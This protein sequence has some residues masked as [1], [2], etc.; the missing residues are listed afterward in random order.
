MPQASGEGA[1]LDIYADSPRHDVGSLPGHDLVL[2]IAVAEFL[3]PDDVKDRSIFQAEPFAP[4]VC[5]H[6]VV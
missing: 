2:P 5:A 4:V 6:L 1:Q 3:S